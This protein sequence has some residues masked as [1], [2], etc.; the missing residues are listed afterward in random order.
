[1]GLKDL[2]AIALKGGEE[3]ESPETPGMDKHCNISSFTSTIMTLYFC[4]TENYTQ[5]RV[6]LS[7]RHIV[8]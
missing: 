1:M 3:E 6:K 8:I 4:E 7:Y 5:S 2:K